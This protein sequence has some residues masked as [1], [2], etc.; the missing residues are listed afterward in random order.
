MN[1][2]AERSLLRDAFGLKGG[3]DGKALENGLPVNMEK[4]IEI[5]EKYQPDDT[6]LPFIVG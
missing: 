3:A 6:D 2:E 4:L 1:L 5:N